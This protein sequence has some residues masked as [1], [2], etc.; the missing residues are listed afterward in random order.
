MKGLPEYKE[1]E[2]DLA[3]EALAAGLSRSDPQ[4]VED[5]LRRTH[6]PIYA[7]AARLTRDPDQRHDW[8]QDVLLKIIQEM[9][10]GRFVYQRPGCF[11]AWFKMR[12]N[13]LLINRYHQHKK[14]NERWN[15]GEVGAALVDRMPMKEGADP[16]HL[17]EAVEARRVVEECMDELNSEDHRQALHL[18]LFH[19]QA[20]QEVAD[21]MGASLNT[22]RSWVRR[23]RVAMR[24]CVAGKFDYQGTE[25][26]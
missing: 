5:F 8:S 23:A 24:Q 4:H 14:H 3:E 19:E 22:V 10:A 26:S 18:V 2:R 6:R 7:M 25:N 9:A 12:A 20:Y 13:F 21:A 1:T 17:L 15:T 16:E 11:W